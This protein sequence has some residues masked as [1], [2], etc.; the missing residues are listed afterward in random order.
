MRNVLLTLL[1]KKP[2]ACALIICMA[3]K[4]AFLDLAEDNGLQSFSDA[5]ESSLLYDFE[6]VPAEMHPH[7]A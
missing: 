5:L 2:Y 6:K 4:E 1:S 7:I 3:E